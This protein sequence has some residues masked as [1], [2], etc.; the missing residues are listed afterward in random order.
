M[1][2]GPAPAPNA[3]PPAASG[4]TYYAPPSGSLT[5]AED[6]AGAQ[7]AYNKALIR[8]N[9]QRQG[10]LQQ[11]GYG[12]NI[13][14][15]SGML[16]N[17]HVDTS[18]VHGGLQQLLHNQATEDQNAQYAA[19][20][21]GLV[22]GLANQGASELHYEHGAQSS[23]LANQLLGNLNDI[24]NG[25]LDAKSA[26]DQALWQLTH[27]AT[28]DAISTGDYNPADLTGTDGGGDGGGGGAGAGGNARAVGTPSQIARASM[29]AKVAAQKAHESAPA[30]AL[31][32]RS[33]GMNAAYHLATRAAAKKTANAYLTN[34]NKRG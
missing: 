9:S 12:G 25:Q 28:T 30:V 10:L 27:S 21:R 20:D 5:G 29:A 3:P 34:K 11:Y 6:Y 1:S 17:L 19:Q 16:T 33:A 31:A 26:L 14:P 4:G 2:G 8:F 32:A 15:T 23:G 24:N 22:G 18:N 7:D 13:D